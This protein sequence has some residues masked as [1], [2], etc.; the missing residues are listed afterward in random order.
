MRRH[1]A[2]MMTLMGGTCSMS[3]Y[4]KPSDTTVR[5]NAIGRIVGVEF[6]SMV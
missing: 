6:Y 4:I 1:V 2:L 5:P 3:K